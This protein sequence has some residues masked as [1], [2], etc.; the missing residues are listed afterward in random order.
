M[1]KEVVVC[2]Y[3]GIL[4][5]KRNKCESVELRWMNVELIIWSEGSQKDKYYMLTHIYEM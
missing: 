5:I 3:N 1:D 2:I 4:V